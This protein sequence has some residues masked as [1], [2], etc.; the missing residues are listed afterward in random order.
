MLCW[1]SLARGWGLEKRVPLGCLSGLRP[2]QVETADPGAGGVVSLLIEETRVPAR[3]SI[4]GLG[5]SSGG[6][7]SEGPAAIAKRMCAQYR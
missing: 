4:K 1:L 2:R 7:M 5:P 3:A 6:E